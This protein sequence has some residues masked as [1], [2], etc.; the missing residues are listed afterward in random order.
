MYFIFYSLRFVGL[1]R[2]FISLLLCESERAPRT[3]VN[4][5]EIVFSPGS[6]FCLLSLELYINIINAPPSVKSYF[7]LK[8][9]HHHSCATTTDVLSL[10]FHLSCLRVQR[11][12]TPHLRQSNHIQLKCNHHRSCDVTTIEYAFLCIQVCS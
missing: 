3:H 8:C 6:V 7:Q 5:C 10:Y 4:M 1:S 9:N 12:V 11:Y 2:L